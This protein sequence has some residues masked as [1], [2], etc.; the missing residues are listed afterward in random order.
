MMGVWVQLVRFVR[1][2]CCWQQ[3]LAQRQVA[4]G[5][6]EQHASMQRCSVEQP[7]G[8][9]SAG[10]TAAEGARLRHTN[11]VIEGCL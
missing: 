1:G 6:A 4:Q 11:T 5:H 8:L 10:P 9:C 3:Q 2:Q 7:A